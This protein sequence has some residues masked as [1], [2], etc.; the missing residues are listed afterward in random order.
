MENL[1]TKV[2]EVPIGKERPLGEAREIESP[3]VYEGL[4]LVES[5]NYDG[6]T[7]IKYWM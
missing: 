5:A 7:S 4:T 2:G 6:K 3:A 1:Q